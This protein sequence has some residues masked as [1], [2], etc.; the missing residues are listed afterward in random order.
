[1]DAS[2]LHILITDPH[3]GGGGQVSY[4]TRL[5]GELTRMGHRVAIGCRPGSILVERAREAECAVHDRFRFRGGLRPGNWLCDIHEIRRYIRDREPDVIHVNGSQDHWVCALGNRLSGSPI[6]IVRTRHNTY[7]VKNNFPNRILNRSWT[8]YQIV[9]CDVVRRR[10]AQHPAFDARRM[11]TIHNGVDPEEF[12]PDSTIR[13]SMRREL[14]YRPEDTV[15]GIAARL[16]PAKGH[17][18]LFRAAAQ[19]RH[20][21]PDLRILVLGQGDLEGGLKAMTRELAM[22]DMVHFAGFRNDIGRCTQAFD[23]GVLPSIDCDTSSFSLKEEMAMEK[24]VIASDYGGLKEIVSNGVEGL[25][26]PAGSI[27]T[28]ASALRRLLDNRDVCRRMG[29]AG[30]KRVLRDFSLAVFAERTAAAYYRAIGLHQNRP[31]E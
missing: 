28:L 19:I 18:F 26:V 6:C 4:L 20:L 13:E 8:D 22:E 29:A 27:Q 25:V 31:V 12:R 9:V 17:E 7:P 2:P 16:V 30:R 23:I 5:A 3:L 11:C 1:M 10:L 24:P 15:L 21:Y 14:G